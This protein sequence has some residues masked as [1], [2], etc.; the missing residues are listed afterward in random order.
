MKVLTRRHGPGMLA[1]MLLLA[2]ACSSSSLASPASPHSRAGETSPIQHVV[3]IMQEN[4]TFDNLFGTFPGVNGFKEAHAANP[5]SG[6]IDHS[7]P[8]ARAAVDG[9]KLDGFSARGQVQYHEADIPT[10]WAYARR[11]GL[12]DN[13]FSSDVTSS[14]PNHIAMFAGQT[15]GNDQ[16][17]NTG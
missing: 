14:T 1:L 4:H 11:F 6:D 10:Y 12:S 8:A 17:V 15:G 7:G 13:F 16:I 2:L 5:L 9:G 3:V